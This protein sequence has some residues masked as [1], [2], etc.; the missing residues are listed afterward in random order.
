[1]TKRISKRIPNMSIRVNRE[2]IKL[3]KIE[4]IKADMTLGEWLEA[5]IKEKIKR[6]KKD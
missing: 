4:A 3:A 1:M 5:A 2:A 6:G